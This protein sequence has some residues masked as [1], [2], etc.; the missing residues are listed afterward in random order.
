MKK[1][2][3]VL[4]VLSLCVVITVISTLLRGHS[5]AVLNPAGVV[6]RKERNLI[7]V[8]LSLSLLVIVPVFVMTGYIV[9]KYRVGNNSSK[10]SQKPRKYEPDWDHSRLAETI[11][12]LIPSALIA[13][14]AVIAWNGSHDLDPF[15]PLASA[16]RPITV[17]VVALDWKWLF[18]YPEQQ[19]ASVNLLEFPKNTPINM[20]VTAD[21]PM[22]SLWIPQLSGQVYAMSGMMTQLH[23]MAD[24]T[25]DFRGV[26]ANISGKGFSGMHFIARST[27]QASYET[28]LQ[29]IRTNS[30]ALNQSEYESLALP[31]E[32]NSPASYSPVDAN[33]YDTI[34]KKYMSSDTGTNMNQ[35]MPSMVGDPSAGGVQ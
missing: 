11:W 1:H 16:N 14:L 30:N 6:A 13:V 5:F 3:I 22:N 23:V 24:K 28:W 18:I 33:L 26:S 27:D 9:M 17:E 21:A 15:K 25:G 34:L 8:A 35:T 4:Y 10:N 19:I 29:S 32:N 31:S 20:Y 2:K 12:W 7:V